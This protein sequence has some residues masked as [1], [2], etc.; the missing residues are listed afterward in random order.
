MVSCVDEE[1]LPLIFLGQ[2]Q[3]NNGLKRCQQAGEKNSELAKPRKLRKLVAEESFGLTAQLKS[4]GRA[5]K[6]A[7]LVGGTAKDKVK[8]RAAVKAE[9]KRSRRRQAGGATAGCLPSLSTS[10]CG[11]EQL[12]AVLELEQG[13]VYQQPATS[14]F[15]SNG[16][17]VVEVAKVEQ[18]VETSPAKSPLQ[19]PGEVQE[20]IEHV[21]MFRRSIRLHGNML[22]QF[23]ASVLQD[24]AK[25]Q[26]THAA[27]ALMK[28]CCRLECSFQLT[29][30]FG[31]QV[32]WLTMTW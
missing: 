20:G 18:D 14:S 25:K 21:H 8:S 22:L 11:V 10:T 4:S 16:A 1:D 15:A 27:H 12:E 2:Q 9:S 29:N 6:Q 31:V 23:G 5:P 28:R 17:G 30:L 3:P 24:V 32:T 7:Q 13:Q 19:F 26:H